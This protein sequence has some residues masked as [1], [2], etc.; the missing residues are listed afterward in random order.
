M[1]AQPMDAEQAQ[2]KQAP[3]RKKSSLILDRDSFGDESKC[4]GPCMVFLLMRYQYQC[5]LLLASAA[6]AAL[7]AA[8]AV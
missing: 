8:A 6:A 3:S 1:S 2:M 5:W 7:A 4:P